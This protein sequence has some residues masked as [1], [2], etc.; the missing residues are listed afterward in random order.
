MSSWRAGTGRSAT[1][2]TPASCCWPS[3]ATVAALCIRW[4]DCGAPARRPGRLRL[5]PLAG[6]RW[7]LALTVLGTVVFRGESPKPVQAGQGPLFNAFVYTLDLLIPIGGLGQRS[8]WY[9]PEGSLAQWL[10]YALIAAGWVLTTA[11]VAGVTRSLN[12]S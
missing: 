9:W 4:A 3:S 11:V 1:R 5:P 2:T 8:A 6:R 10:S 12:K 7:I